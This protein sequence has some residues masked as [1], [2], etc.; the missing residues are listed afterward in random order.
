[1]NEILHYFTPTKDAASALGA[2]A[3]RAFSDTFAPLY[4]PVPFEQFL[5]EAYGPGG[6]M[7]SD[8]CDP[9]VRWQVA[10]IGDQLIG[11][12]KLSPLRASAPEPQPGAVELQQIYVLS[13]WQGQGV[14][15]RLMNWALDT[16]RADGASEIYLTVFDHNARAKRFYSRHGFSEVGRCTFRLGD[17]VDDDRVWRRIL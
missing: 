1:M 9:S 16:A 13:R 11:Y 5:D 15:E 12:V 7:E 17:R 8:L 6:A 3:R 10:A 14:A 4:D 2:M